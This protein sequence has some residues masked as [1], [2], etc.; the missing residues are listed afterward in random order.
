LEEDENTIGKGW[1]AEMQ[2]TLV[3]GGLRRFVGSIY[4]YNAKNVFEK[5]FRKVS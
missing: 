1:R 5:G 3:D 4:P 2:P